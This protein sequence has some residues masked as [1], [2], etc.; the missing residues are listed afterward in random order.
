MAG[1]PVDRPALPVLRT[2]ARLLPHGARRRLDAEGAPDGGR[3]TT[4]TAVS[5]SCGS[6]STT[7]PRRPMRSACVTGPRPRSANA[8]QA[9]VELAAEI[10]RVYQ[11]RPWPGLLDAARSEAGNAEA[12]LKPVL[13]EAGRDV[14]HGQ[15]RHR[16]QRYAAAPCCASCATSCPS[17]KSGA[18]RLTRPRPVAGDRGRAFPPAAPGCA[19]RPRRRA[20]RATCSCWRMR[21]QRRPTAPA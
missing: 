16:L 13:A 1:Q 2:S 10:D 19:R 17:L 20:A 18:V 21:V 9:R 7:A 3:W 14:R 11:P 5:R 6:R 8:E 4:A 15:C 12:A